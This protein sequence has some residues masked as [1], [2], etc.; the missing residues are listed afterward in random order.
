[1]NKEHTRRLRLRG[2][3]FGRITQKE[4]VCDRQKDA[5]FELINDAH[6][7]FL[8]SHVWLWLTDGR[9]VDFGTKQ[10]TNSDTFVPETGNFRKDSGQDFL[11]LT[12]DVPDLGNVPVPE[13]H[14]ACQHSS[15]GR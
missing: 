3:A 7:S 4:I 9:R 6:T 14:G 15:L 13:C 11:S 12:Y 8:H 5:L 2:G 10:S 1:M